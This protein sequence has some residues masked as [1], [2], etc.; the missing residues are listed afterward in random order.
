MASA[1]APIKVDVGT[2]ELISHAAHFLGKS[3]KDVVDA[4]VRE[5]V[6]AHRSEINAGV[7]AAL[8]RLDGSSKSAVALLADVSP[9]QLDE[10]GG[11]PE[12]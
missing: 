1:S 12:D 4:A 7:R 10:Y 8:G 2:D 6:D 5:Y 9:D 3:K 11:L